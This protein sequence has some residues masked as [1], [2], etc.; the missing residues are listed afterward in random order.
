VQPFAAAFVS[1]SM[2]NVYDNDSPKERTTVEARQAVSG[3]GVRYVLA[4]S[5]GAALVGMALAYHFLF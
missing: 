1:N 4:I 2:S 3:M 5:L